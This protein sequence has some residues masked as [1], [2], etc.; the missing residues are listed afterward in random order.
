MKQVLAIYPRILINL[1]FPCLI[2]LR[3]R[4]VDL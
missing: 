3:A 1:Q 4:I 2:L